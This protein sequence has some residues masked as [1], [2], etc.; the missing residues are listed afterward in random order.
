MLSQDGSMNPSAALQAATV[1]RAEGQLVPTTIAGLITTT[2]IVA[3]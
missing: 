2:M 1:Q 3:K